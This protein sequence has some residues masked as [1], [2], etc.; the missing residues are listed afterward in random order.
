MWP[1]PTGE[2]DFILYMEEVEGESMIEGDS[3][4][5]KV[6]RGVR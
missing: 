5:F 6:A 2:Q 3:R 4:W 1:V